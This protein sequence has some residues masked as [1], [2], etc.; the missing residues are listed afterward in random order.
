MP[1]RLA[2]LF[3]VSLCFALLCFCWSGLCCWGEGETLALQAP[4]VC[5]VPSPSRLLPCHRVKG[6]PATHVAVFNTTTTNCIPVTPPSRCRLA[7]GEA[8]A[9]GGTRDRPARA[10]ENC[11]QETIGKGKGFPL[12]SSSVPLLLTHTLSRPSSPPHT[13]PLLLAPVISILFRTDFSCG[14][15]RPPPVQLRFFHA[16]SGA[17]INQAGGR[18]ERQGE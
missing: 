10:S 6:S 4:P 2:C 12:P 11:R 8:H 18:G 15:S 17:S 16:R 5:S 3:A 14:L 7:S 9:R 13:F 1:L